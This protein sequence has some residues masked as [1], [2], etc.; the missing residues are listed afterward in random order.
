MVGTALR[1]RLNWIVAEVVDLVDET[2]KVRSIVL[3]CPGWDG[4]LAG[5]HI[6]V[7]LTAEDGY[8]AQRSYS[9]ATPSDG[10]LVTISVEFVDDGEVSPYLVEVLQEGDRIEIRGPIGGYFVWAP[11]RGGPL[12]LI[13]G[14]S[15]VAPLMAMLRQRVASGSDV[16]V[17]YLSSARTYEDVLYRSELDHLS[18]RDGIE[19]VHTLTRSHP[20][21]WSGPTR[22]V[23]REILEEHVW[24][25]GERPLCYVCGPTGFV[26]TVATTLTEIGHE[27][28]RIKTE[29]FG[30][31]GG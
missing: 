17:R 31:S 23:D 15:G 10:D 26:E 6:D 5:Q 7:R 20:D 16:P 4:H 30:P 24:P 2:P 14:G 12:Q 18:E 13:G 1:R 27:P 19:V 8:Q 29:R 11:D 21:F 22:R 9:I 25:V 28:D 3:R